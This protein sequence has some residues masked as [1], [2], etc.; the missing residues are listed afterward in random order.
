MKDRLRIAAIEPFFGGSHR[1]FLEGYRKYSRHDV[2]I[3]PLPARK[4]KWR[5]RGS[6][7]YF[8]ETL[9]GRLGGFDLVFAS[10]FL[11]LAEFVALAPGA[12]RIPKVVYFH[13]NQLTYPVREESER[14]YQFPFTNVTTCLAADLVL[15]NSRFHRESFLGAVGPFL[16][17][18]PDF[19]PRGTVAEIEAKSRVLHLGVDVE[20]VR[21]M[22]RGERAGA[23]LV[24]WNHRWEF[25]KNPETFF[26]TL[27]ALKAQ[28]VDFR[29]AV[30]G[31]HYRETPD[32]FDRARRE[33]A[34]E[35]VQFG[36]L[37]S[38]DDYLQLLRRCDIVASTAIHDFFGVAVVE[39]IAAGCWP[40]L[41]ERLSY[42]ELLPA[43][44]H[45]RH[46]YRTD[47]QFRRRLLEALGGIDKVR[48]TDVS[49]AVGRFA[50]ETIVG[51][52]D[53]T[54]CEVVEGFSA[55]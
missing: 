51:D 20:P 36:H 13:E 38:R 27:I 43:E 6:A 32:V 14:D 26:E 22:A 44:L 28:G 25:D 47:A 15:F 37:Q 5:M 34:D 31:E 4:W 40:L 33:L 3:F 7:I 30:A 35:I 24:L 29:L 8:A 2:E 45:R 19:E 23:G 11:N 21:A 17:R 9:R 48:E 50:W 46:L 41:P 54:M 49:G 55:R 42:P 12:A 16:K 39:A 53:R 10:D 1:A 52:Y 18:M